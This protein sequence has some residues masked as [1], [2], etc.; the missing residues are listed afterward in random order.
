MVYYKLVKIT[1]GAPGLAEVIIKVVIW[2]H[3]LSNS[4]VSDCGSV[5]ISKFWFSLYYF[6]GIKQK[7]LTVFH[8]QTNSQRERQ[9]STMEAYL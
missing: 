2:H 6:L 8:P 9:N 5:F 3:G 4:I 7:L 1:I